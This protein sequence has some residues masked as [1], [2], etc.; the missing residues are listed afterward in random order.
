MLTYWELLQLILPVFALIAIGV[1][2]RRVH[3]VE[4][5]AESSLIKM[6]I[7]LFM[8]CLIFE[9]V[10]GN[11]ALQT[12]GN[13]VLPPLV[14]F[15]TSAL[16]IGA[17][18]QF[19]KWLGLAQGTG[20]RT[21]ALATGLANYGYL[22]LP[23]VTGMFGA[24]SRGVL[25]VHNIGV[26]AA[27]WTVGVLVLSGWSLAEAR[28]RLLSPIVLTL[29]AAI[30]VNVS[31]LSPALPRLLM[32][33]IRTLA[34]C[35]IPLGLLMTGINLADHLGEPKRLFEPRVSLGSV[36]LR[37][38]VL[39]FFFLALARWLPCSIELKRVIVVQG[40]MPT[41]VIPIIIAHHYGGRPL[42]AV[43]VVLATTAVAVV[44]TPLWLRVGL[45]WAGV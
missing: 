9:S 14:G 45:S 36:A 13:L 38:G 29:F 41:A 34:V 44:I 16:T 4:G 25:L 15:V 28:R 8:P 24:E 23:I 30:A 42:T 32:D 26:E 17:A 22:P 40:A 27:V 31:G 19:A 2:L 33:V 5:V 21:F 11:A 3:W 12:P 10:V 18:Y 1:A 39:P 35:A 7:N 43:Q 37:L 20:L 6:V